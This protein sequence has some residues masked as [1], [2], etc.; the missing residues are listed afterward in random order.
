M[1]VVIGGPK[2]AMRSTSRR[3]CRLADHVVTGEADLAFAGLCREL[4]DGR[5]PSRKVI[6]SPLPT[7]D[8]VA[9]P[10]ALYNDKDISHRVIYVEASR[11]CPYS[12]EFCL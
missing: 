11:G 12:C 1:I 2:S 4:L 8:R 7:L 6:E 3:S 10:Y 9:L 5:A